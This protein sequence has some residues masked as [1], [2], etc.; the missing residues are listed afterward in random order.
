[1]CS[2]EQLG[3]NVTPVSVAAGGDETDVGGAA[4]EE[5]V[6]DKASGNHQQVLEETAVAGARI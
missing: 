1:L 6:K 4:E 5:V 2:R 3:S